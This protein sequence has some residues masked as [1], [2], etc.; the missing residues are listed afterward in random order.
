[1]YE[2]KKTK[3]TRSYSISLFSHIPWVL[4]TFLTLFLIMLVA[5]IVFGFLGKSYD[6]PAFA[7]VAEELS[8]FLKVVIGAI[9]GS[10]S[11][12]AKNYLQREN[13]EL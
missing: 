8:S 2:E 10:L 6:V 4:R 13:S 7:Q 5:I 1:M 12:E 11:S 9:I 3:D